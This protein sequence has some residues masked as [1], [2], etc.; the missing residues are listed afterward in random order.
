MI[1]LGMAF[2]S[3]DRCF[4]ISPVSPPYFTSVK[5]GSAIVDDLNAVRGNGDV[6]DDWT[7]DTIL[8]AKFEENLLAGNIDYY[9]SSI[10]KVRLK[11][12]ILGEVVWQT[13]FE[14]SIESDKDL[15]FDWHDTT[16]R[17]S[18]EYEYTLVPVFGDVEGS[19]FTNSILSEFS[20]VF[21]IDS[22][23]IYATELEI[24]LSEARNR[25]VG[26]VAPA[27][28]KYPYVIANGLNNY[29]SGSLSAYFVEKKDGQYD[30]KGGFS[31]RRRLKDFLYNGLP[32]LLKMDDGRMW[33]VGISSSSI[34]D[35]EQ[36]HYEF[37]TT[38]FDWTEIGDCD[39]FN[40]LK[41]SGVVTV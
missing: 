35:S 15:K 29:D 3:D 39:S 26:V 16:A 6:T 23:G 22:T 36:G 37:I 20:G 24:E 10:D 4:G 1:F 21:I 8:H 40:E 33:L 38:S 32:K 28:R 17:G 13:I 2:A 31:H 7:F 11:R 34:Q 25:Q 19:F 30:T 18:T 27:N 9:V 12:R 41:A 5:V 14:R